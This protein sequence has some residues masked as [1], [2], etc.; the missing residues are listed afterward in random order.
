MLHT[1]S[2]LVA[3]AVQ[4][5][6]V[7]LL[8]HVISRE[9]HAMARLMPFAGRTVLLRASGWPSVLPAVPDLLLGVT[10]AGLWERL[11]AAPGEA[12]EEVLRVELD[13]SNPALLALAGL[14]GERPRVIVQ[15]DAAFA[16]EINWLI[17]NLRWDI[18]DE[19]AA[20]IGPAPAHQLAGWGRAAAQALAGLATA[21]HK[22]TA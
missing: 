17:A 5:R 16:A 14:A 10:A 3:P 18:E 9:S 8:N 12:A 6:M 2:S 21:M 19:L 1:W 11:D 15:G 20:L 22:K 13:A 4:D 7:L